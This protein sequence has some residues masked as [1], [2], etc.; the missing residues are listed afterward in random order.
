MLIATLVGCNS[1]PARVPVPQF[2]VDEISKQALQLFDRNHDGQLSATECSKSLSSAMRRVDLDRDDQISADEIV[3]RLQFYEQ[4]RAGLVPVFC[5]LTRGGRPVAGAK[6]T[7][8]PEQF[9]G[10]G[11]LPGFGTTDVGGN[12]VISV[13][14]EHLPS[15]NHAGLQPGFYRVLVELSDGS[16]VAN[17][18]AGA[19][20]A[21]DV[22]NTH[23]FSLP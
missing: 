9:M 2:D 20:C 17:F 11:R 7:Y 16:K 8:E 3:K 12:A 19:E 13:G 10:Q 22:Q 6:I 15:P 23:S 14:A 21:G 18:D 4:Y 1:R 5:T